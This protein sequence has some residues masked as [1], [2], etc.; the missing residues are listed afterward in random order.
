MKKKE[1]WAATIL[2]NPIDETLTTIKGF[3]E[4]ERN[5]ISS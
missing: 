4:E 3:S 1:L 2:R 5:V